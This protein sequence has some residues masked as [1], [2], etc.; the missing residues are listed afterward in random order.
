MQTLL[1]HQYTEPIESLRGPLEDALLPVGEGAPDAAIP[2]FS[3]REP[4]FCWVHLLSMKEA[5]TAGPR[6]RG[7]SGHHEG[8]QTRVL[9]GPSRGQLAGLNWLCSTAFRR[10]LES[11]QNIPRVSYCFISAFIESSHSCFVAC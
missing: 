3:A 7:H 11:P 8:A 2:W 6:M 5:D 9:P 1:H 10:A 4:R